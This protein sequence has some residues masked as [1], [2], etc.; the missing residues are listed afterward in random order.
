[1]VRKNNVTR[2]DT[3]QVLGA[4][5]AVYRIQNNRVVRFENDIPGNKEM[6]LDILAGTSTIQVTED[7]YTRAGEIASYLEQKIMLSTLTGARINDF[8]RQISELANLKE[9]PS[10][11]IGQLVWAPKLHEDS[12]KQD[13]VK[14]DI[15][16]FAFTSTYLGREKDKIE[17]TFN[18]IDVRYLSAYNCFRHV[19]HDGKGNLV[20]FLNKNSIDTVQRIR[21]RIKSCEQSRHYANAKTTQI[22]FVKVV[23]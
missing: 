13:N 4:A 12:V 8:L 11:S 18:P 5:V 6:V 10:N 21:A 15:G 22:N 20:T 16:Q 9:V 2:V 7:D 17:F 3:K 14:Q 1:M 19:G 23:E